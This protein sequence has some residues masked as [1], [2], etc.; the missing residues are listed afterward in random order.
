MASAQERIFVASTLLVLAF[1]GFE[2][3]FVRKVMVRPRCSPSGM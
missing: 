3:L 1:M 2:N